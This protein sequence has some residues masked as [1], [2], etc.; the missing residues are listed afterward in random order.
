MVHVSVAEKGKV[1]Q[2][3]IA[4]FPLNRWMPANKPMQ[5]EKFDSQ[6]PQ[7]VKKKNPKM[8]KQREEELKTKQEAFDYTPIGNIEG[9]PR[10]V[11]YSNNCQLLVL[12]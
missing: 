1:D 12:F 10:S 5:F 2:S 8:Y 11:S 9:M 3:G 6:L 4:H 7:V